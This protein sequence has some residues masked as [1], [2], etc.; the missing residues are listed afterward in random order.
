MRV[1]VAAP[2]RARGPESRTV[3]LCWGSLR[4]MVLGD[5]RCYAQWL[6]PH[7]P[8][9]AVLDRAPLPSVV[10]FVQ[11]D[12]TVEVLDALGTQLRFHPNA[13][14]C[15]MRNSKIEAVHAVGE[16]RLWMQGVQHVYT[17]QPI[18]AREIHHESGGGQNADS[19]QD[20]AERNSG[21]LRDS[22]PAFLARV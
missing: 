20:G 14:W 12:D 2:T 13:Q 3:P 1:F 9:P 16:D 8:R 6:N 4:A 22:V 7:V 5:Q 10:K 19:V 11:Y 17:V 18:V 21:P 15:S